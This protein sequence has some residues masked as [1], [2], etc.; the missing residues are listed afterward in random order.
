MLAAGLHALLA[1][2]PTIAALVS[3]R[4]DPVRLPINQAMPAITFRIVGGSSEPTLE[5]SGLQRVR[6]EIDCFG[7]SYLAA[8]KVRQAVRK[9]LN[10][11]QGLLGDGT[12]LQNADLIQELD[13][14][15]EYAR[16]FRCMAEFYLYFVFPS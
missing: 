7:K 16:E 15:E 2:E 12:Y 10:G 14:D 1:E 3:D 5:T 6:L 4:I 13:F 11:Y 8:A 9:F